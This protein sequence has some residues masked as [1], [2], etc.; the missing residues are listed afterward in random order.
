MEKRLRFFLAL[1]PTSDRWPTLVSVGGLFV[2]LDVING[3]ITTCEE[4]FLRVDNNWFGSGVRS[5]KH[6]LTL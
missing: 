3:N 2:F 1:F 5:K 4:S 6:G